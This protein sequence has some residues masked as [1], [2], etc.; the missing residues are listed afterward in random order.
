MSIIPTVTKKPA[1]M[2]PGEPQRARGGRGG[3]EPR[4]SPAGMPDVHVALHQGPH[5]PQSPAPTAHDQHTVGLL[6]WE[7]NA[8][9]RGAGK[10]Q[11]RPDVQLQRG[12]RELVADPVALGFEARVFR[13]R[14]P[15]KH[16]RVARIACAILRCSSQ[17]DMGRTARPCQH[18]AVGAQEGMAGARVSLVRKDLPVSLQWSYGLL[19]SGVCL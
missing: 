15:A 14:R 13:A 7:A 18:I 1:L 5:W 19:G 10:R 6:P 12:A 16:V 3:G 9:S 17:E 11:V 2:S 8:I 4:H